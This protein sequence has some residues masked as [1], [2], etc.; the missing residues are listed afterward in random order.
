MDLDIYTIPSIPLGFAFVGGED[1]QNRT[2]LIAK[3]KDRIEGNLGKIT[4]DEKMKIWSDLATK[5]SMVGFCKRTRD[6]VRN[7]WGHMTRVSLRR[8]T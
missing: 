4:T 5:V 3:C 8:R 2:E 7:K 6:E 1:Q